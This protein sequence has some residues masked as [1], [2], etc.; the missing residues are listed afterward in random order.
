MSPSVRPGRDRD[1][2]ND[3]FVW[4]IGSLEHNIDLAAR[5]A[6]KRQ[7]EVDLEGANLLE[8]Q[9]K[10]LHV[11]AGIERNLVVGE[12]KSFFLS[13]RK[14]GE[15]N[16]RHVRQPDLTRRSKSSVARDQHRMLV[17]KHRVGEPELSQ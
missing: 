7:V 9:P 4:I 6:G 10:Y 8:F 14:A 13:F 16:T 2:R 3:L 17:D 12:A 1:G 11:P 15:L 5:E